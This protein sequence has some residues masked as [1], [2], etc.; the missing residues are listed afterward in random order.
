MIAKIEKPVNTVKD[1]TILNCSWEK[2][3]NF[4][5]LSIDKE[6]YIVGLTLE[7]GINFDLQKGVHNIQVGKRSMIAHEVVFVV[8]INHNYHGVSMRMEDLLSGVCPTQRLREKGQIIVGNDCWIGRGATVMGG[9]RIHN[10]AVVAANAVVTKDVP[11]YAIVGGNPAKIIGYRC[12]ADTI[13]KLQKISWWEWPDSRI[14]SRKEDFALGLE[15][16]AG[17]Y[18]D[19]AEKEI[20][21][22]KKIDMSDVNPNFYN[23]GRRYLVV[24]DIMERYPTFPRILDEYTKKFENADTELCVYIPETPDKEVI[25]ERILPFFSAYEDKNCNVTLYAAQEDEKQIFKSVTHYITNRMGRNIR[26]MDLAD[27]FGVKC[28][29]GVDFP[30]FE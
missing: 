23:R 30:I 20:N 6:S 21:S 12:C 18:I 28:I 19:E 9:T 14:S 2:G 22:V 24:P 17:K 29:S 5:L 25:V 16:F 13:E 7:S 15:A 1:F 11:P 26:R 3:E 8:N 27:I 10:G 4:P